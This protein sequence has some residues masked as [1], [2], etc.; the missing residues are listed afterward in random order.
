MQTNTVMT[1][2]QGG[3]VYET[4]DVD[5][6]AA[7]SVASFSCLAGASLLHFTE[8]KWGAGCANTQFTTNAVAGLN[9]VKIANY[10]DRVFAE[11]GVTGLKIGFGPLLYIIAAPVGGLVSIPVA[12]TSSEDGK[13]L[14]MTF[15]VPE[16][17]TS[18]TYACS[19]ALIGALL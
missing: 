2:Y 11:Q 14:F 3:K 8:S 13:D 10:W 6:T 9:V 17:G 15:T 19:Q 16:Y 5:I 12:L 7:P 4:A 18:R 1:M